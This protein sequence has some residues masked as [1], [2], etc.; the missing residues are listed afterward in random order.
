MA[1]I[2]G[3]KIF[4]AWAFYSFALLFGAYLYYKYKVR[5]LELEKKSEI[6]D[7]ELRIA[8]L[9]AQIPKPRPIIVNTHRPVRVQETEYNSGNGQHRNG[10]G[11]TANDYDYANTTNHLEGRSQQVPEPVQ[12]SRGGEDP[13]LPAG[14]TWTDF[15]YFVRTALKPDG[16]GLGIGK[17]KSEMKWKQEDIESILDF[18]ADIEVITPR[19]NGRA[20]EWVG[21]WNLASITRRVRND[22]ALPHPDIRP[23]NNMTYR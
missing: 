22:I 20:C 5:Q 6:A 18:L 21:E 15:N 2:D 9:Q 12:A 11:H 17:W 1:Q 4:A 14:V 13:V 7:K 8:E 16:P 19:Q 3:T 10:N 23:V